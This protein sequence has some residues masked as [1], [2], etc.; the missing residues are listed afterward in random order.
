MRDPR[1]ILITGASSGIGAALARA[2]A[3][4]GV[5]L[6]LTGRD[7]VR[8]AEVTAVCLAAGASV[9]EGVVDAADAA[10][11]ARFVETAHAAAPLDLVIANAGISGG[12]YGG[13]ESA[14]Q[15]RAIMAINVDGVLNTVLPALPHMQ[16][17]RRGQIA[18][19]SSL[20]SFRGFP[21]AP[22]YCASKAAVRVWG[23]G[24]RG[25]MRPHGVEVSVICPGFVV[26]PMTAQNRFRMPFLMPAERAVAIIRKGLEADRA[27][28]A[29]PFR[30][31][32]GAWLVG[33]LPPGLTDGWLM[34]LPK[35]E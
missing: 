17:R 12:T 35:K 30:L 1:S 19:M 7:P 33:V 27:R 6:A 34:R 28:I 24:L 21:G 13:G 20:A 8:L 31:Y 25:D 3:A 22:A 10:A 15:V 16:A 9:V 32:V 14:D 5:S 29:F 4:P 26:S 2:Y 18:I 23:E 11:M